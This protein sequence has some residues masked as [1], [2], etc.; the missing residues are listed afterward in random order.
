MFKAKLSQKIQALKPSSTVAVTSRALELK[1]QGVDVISMSVGEPDFDTPEHVKQA[2]YRAIQEGKTKYTPVN[3]I[4]ELRETISEKL[5]RE[6]GLTYSP[7]QV[8]VTSG[9]KQAIF[10]ALIALIDPGDE[11]IIPAPFWVSYPEM[12]TFAGGVPVF[13]DTLAEEG[14]RLDPEKVRAAVTDRTVAIM[15]NSPS[16]PTG[17]VYPEETIKALVNLALEKDLLLITD[18]MYEH[19]IYGQKH[20]SAAQYGNDHV[21]TIN[22][23]SKAYAMTG[24]RIGYAAGPLHLIKAMNA[25][26]GQSTSNANSVAQY[27][28]LEAIRDSYQY[29]EYAREKFRERRDFIVSG[30]N[31]MGLVTPT[32]DGAFYVMVDT[33]PIHTDEIEAARRILDEARV[34]VVP[35]TDFRAPGRI[36]ISYA[37]SMENIEEAL[38]RISTLL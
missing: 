32:P 14:Y 33:T 30:L 28:A 6:N 15:I 10:N 38:K 5:Q 23:A 3:G 35:G 18:E 8:T 20:V 19:I 37:T 7:E 9:G 26:Q 34:A 12:V 31:N 16:N 29:I 25:I 4:F 17:V 13:V 11:V 21:L 22:G 27:A 24:W 1:R 36:R 2:A